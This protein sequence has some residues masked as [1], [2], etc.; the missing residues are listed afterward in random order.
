MKAQITESAKP[1][2]EPLDQGFPPI[3]GPSSQEPGRDREEQLVD[4]ALVKQLT[5]QCGPAL[6]EDDL[7]P[8][9]LEHLQ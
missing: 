2:T 4:H 1:L 6:D 7:W 9:F 3:P 8:F 5:E